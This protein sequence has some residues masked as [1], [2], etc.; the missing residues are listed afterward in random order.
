M[1]AS[2]CAVLLMDLQADF[3]ARA[4]ARMPVLPA[5]AERVIAS[6]NDVLHGRAL[7]GCL[8]AFVVNRFPRTD[9]LANRFRHGAAVEGTPGAALDSRI[10]AHSGVPVFPKQRA[11]AFTNP[12]LDYWLRANA[13]TRLYVL[14]VFAE[15]C[16][17]ATAIDARQRG[18]A[19]SVPLDAIGTSS[20]W[21]RRVAAWSMRRAGVGL[22]PSLPETI[23]AA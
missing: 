2:R 9:R 7:A 23:A 19:V 18:Y 22:L 3:L 13:V 20:E 1:A 6:A 8:P 15:G 4:G 10:E 11:S 14:G 16:V 12:D 17:R 5:D 21:R